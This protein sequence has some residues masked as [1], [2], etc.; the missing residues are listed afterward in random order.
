VFKL[1]EIF[2]IL[3]EI[4]NNN[5]QNE[6]Y[7]PDVVEIYRRKNQSFSDLILRDYREAL[8]ANTKEELEQ[9]NYIY[10]LLFASEKKY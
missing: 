7:L 2:S 10:H 6:Y 4:K 3:K 1:P 9:L 8:G 5:N